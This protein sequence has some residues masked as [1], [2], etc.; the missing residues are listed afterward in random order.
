MTFP[1]PADDG[2]GIAVPLF[3]L[4]KHRSGT[5]WLANQLAA[6]SAIAAVTHPRHHGVH[7]SAYFAYIV[8]RYGPVSDRLNYEELVTVLERSDYFQLAG[9]GRQEM[10]DLWPSSYE[11]LFRTLMG[12]F[13]ARNSARYWLE[14]TPTHSLLVSELAS[15]YPDAKFVA[16]QRDLTAVVA[17]T[18]RHENALGN[19]ILIIRTV[20]GWLYYSR[21]LH[22]FGRKSERMLEVEYDDLQRDLEATLRDICRFLAID[23]EAGML[24]ERFA[25]NT[26]FTS[27][28]E[29][30]ATLS[31]MD[32]GLIRVS[33]ALFTLVPLPLMRLMMRARWSASRPLPE[34]FFA[35]PRGEDGAGA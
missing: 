12:R 14:K 13:A 11:G 15:H 2:T 10:L 35:D 3:V 22:A 25:A 17:S 20:F 27:N 28:R 7:E 21:V 34:W 33:R 23:F 8:G 24:A 18:I 4:G 6:H 30:Q 32:R 1:R 31:G 19:H 9:F 26:S 5:T 29:R 16:V